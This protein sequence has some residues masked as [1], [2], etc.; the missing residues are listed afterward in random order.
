[1][2]NLAVKGLIKL[3][4]FGSLDN[5]KNNNVL[6]NKELEKNASGGQLTG[7]HFNSTKLRCMRFYQR[8]QRVLALRLIIMIYFFRINIK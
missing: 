4:D 8:Q 6:L 1:M 2:N 5:K 3:K 7:C